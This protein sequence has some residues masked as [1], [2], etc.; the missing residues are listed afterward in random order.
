[1]LYGKDV[2]R[3]GNGYLDANAI[4]A[5]LSNGSSGWS[6]LGPV[7]SDENGRRAAELANAG[8][9][10]VAVMPN[11]SGHGHIALVLP[12][13]ATKVSSWGVLAPNSAAFKFEAPNSKS[14]YVGKPLS[15]AFRKSEAEKTIYYYSDP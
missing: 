12:G 2:F 14:S 13:A 5:K 15:Y 9:I 10:V 8:K 6:K 1:M 3:D 7:L 4:S 11:P